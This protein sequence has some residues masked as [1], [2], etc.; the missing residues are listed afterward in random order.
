MVPSV[1]L[2]LELGSFEDL[3]VVIAPSP[4]QSSASID[5]GVLTHIAEVVFARE[6]SG[7][8]ASLGFSLVIARTLTVS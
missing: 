2:H 5:S 8:L 4:P 7:L 3:A 1:V 6:L